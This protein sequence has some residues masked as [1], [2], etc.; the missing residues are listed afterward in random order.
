MRESVIVRRFAGYVVIGGG[1][2]A[3]DFAVFLLAVNVGAGVVLANLAA[4]LCGMVVSFLLNGYLNFKATDH[5]LQRFAKF[6]M[7]VATGYLV[8]TSVILLLTAASVPV[9][10]AKLLSMGVVLALQFTLNSSWTFR[11]SG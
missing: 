7:V 4:T 1:A 2:A 8:G 5:L 11:T 10:F 6:V 9:A 3:V